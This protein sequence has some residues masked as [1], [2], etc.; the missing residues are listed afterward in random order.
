MT[1]TDSERIAAIRARRAAVTRGG[2]YLPAD[3][4]IKDGDGKFIFH[5]AADIDYLLATLH[6]KD[7]ALEAY[8]IEVETAQTEIARLTAENIDWREERER[9]EDAIGMLNRKI[10][11]MRRA[12]LK[13]QYPVK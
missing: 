3:D 6:N 5:A 1:T 2:V 12:E 4:S 7:V 13:R 9:M 10:D 11:T 8:R